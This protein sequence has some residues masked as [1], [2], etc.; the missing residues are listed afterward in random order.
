MDLTKPKDSFHCF[1]DNF[2]RGFDIPIIHVN[3]DDVHSCIKAINVYKKKFNKDV[4]DLVSDLTKKWMLNITQPVMYKGKSSTITEIYSKQLIKEG[5][6]NEIDISKIKDNH[7]D[8][9]SKENDIK[10]TKQV[11]GRAN[12]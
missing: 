9:L 3:G 11:F 1:I 2:V 12:L 5:I 4:V 8:T 7:T 10:F 6:I